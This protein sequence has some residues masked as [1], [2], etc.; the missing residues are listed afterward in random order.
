LRD[1]TGL[2]EEGG[3]GLPKWTSAPLWAFLLIILAET[4][5]MTYGANLSGMSVIVAVLMHA[6]F[7]TCSKLFNGLIASA[8]IRP[9][10]SPALIFTVSPLLVALLL[11][12]CT[13]GRLGFPT[14][15]DSTT[16]QD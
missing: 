1:R 12:A 4:L 10:P 14:T 6:T 11:V 7:N 8:S 3:A 5:L 9:S 13:R 2:R 15:F 16:Q